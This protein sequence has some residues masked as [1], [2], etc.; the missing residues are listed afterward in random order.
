MSITSAVERLRKTDPTRLVDEELL[1]LMTQGD[2]HAFGVLYDRYSTMTYSLAMRLLRDRGAA[3][4]LVQ[5]AFLAAWRT[6]GAY[7]TAR[8][9]ACTW[10][11]AIVHHR[12]VDRLRAQAASCRRDDALRLAALTDWEGFDL[13]SEEAVARLQS[14]VVRRAMDD[15][16]HNQRQVLRLAYFGGFTHPEIA[17]ILRLPLGT[18]KGRL[19]LA[20]EHLR[21]SLAGVD[22]E[23]SPARGAH[24]HQ[25]QSTRRVVAHDSAC[26]G[27]RSHPEQGDVSRFSCSKEALLANGSPERISE[28]DAGD[29]MSDALPRAN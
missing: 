27:A 13:T 4:D 10:L 24:H 9:S 12:A 23:A 29:V 5:E 6:A 14:G 16:P 8:G 25:T 7:S 2:E 17:E 26:D 11:L 1:E 15:L 3:E 21:G 22:R 28:I 18:V 19:R 20:L